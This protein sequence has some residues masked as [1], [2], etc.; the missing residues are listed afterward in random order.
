MRLSPL[1]SPGVQPMGAIAASIGSGLPLSV[2]G[3]NLSWAGAV[4][5]YVTTTWSVR[6]S[7]MHMASE[8]PRPHRSVSATDAPTAE[9]QDR[10]W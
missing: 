3:V 6:V 10:M 4:G 9:I 1:K 7:T 5:A 2:N 8:R